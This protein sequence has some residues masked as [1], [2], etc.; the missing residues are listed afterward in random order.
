MGAGY[1]CPARLTE[2]PSDSERAHPTY[3]S[4]PWFGPLSVEAQEADPASTLN[5]YRL[6]LTWRRRLRLI[7]LGLHRPSQYHRHGSSAC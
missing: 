2:L 5:F 4:P 6:A 1:R 3:P 7:G